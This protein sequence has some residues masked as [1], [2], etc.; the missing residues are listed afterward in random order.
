MLRGL[1]TASSAMIAQQRRHDAVT[2]NIAN[3]NTPGY[4]ETGAVT[5][6]FPDM[7]ISAMGG[8]NPSVEPI[9]KLTTGVFAEENLLRMSQ[10]DLTETYRPSDM[11]IVSDI[12]VEGTPFDA[13]GKYVNPDTGDVT[14]QPQS[15]FTVQGPDGLPRYTR[16]GSFRTGAD[17]TLL[18]ATGSAVLGSDGQPIIINGP[19]EDIAVIGNGQLVNKATGLPL[20]GN[21]RLMLTQVDNPNDLLREGNGTFRYEGDAGG[22]RAVDP[23]DPNVRV[24]VKQGFLERSNVD[25]AQ[26]MVDIMA[27]LRSYEANQKV[28]QFYDRSLERAVNDVGK[29]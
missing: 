16:D 15:Y 1:Y 20:G 26:S 27:A 7:L 11:A 25:S 12:L 9:G 21:L 14:Y 23:N 29:V 10:G 6:S 18:T 19:W 17:G 4:K 28:I 5:R 13:S 8:P 22:V 2:N 24:A 3:L